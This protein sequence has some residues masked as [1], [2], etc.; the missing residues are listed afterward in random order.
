MEYSMAG[1]YHVGDVMFF[2]I[3]DRHFE[4]RNSLQGWSIKSVCDRLLQNAYGYKDVVKVEHNDL[5]KYASKFRGFPFTSST[6]TVCHLW[7]SDF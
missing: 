3:C 5:Q 7:E 2:L 1:I 6:N 4:P